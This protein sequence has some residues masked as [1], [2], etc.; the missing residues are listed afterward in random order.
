MER[1]QSVSESIVCF[2]PYISYMNEN[3]PHFDIIIE[4]RYRQNKEGKLTFFNIINIQNI[5]S[6]NL[7]QYKEILQQLSTSEISVGTEKEELSLI[8][9]NIYK[10]QESQITEISSVCKFFPYDPFMCKIAAE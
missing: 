7:Y 9:A 4:N 5:L 6:Q 2:D 3:F 1:K 8:Y 10:L